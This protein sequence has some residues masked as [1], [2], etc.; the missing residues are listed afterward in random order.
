MCKV[1]YKLFFLEVWKLGDRY[2]W[3]ITWMVSITSLYCRDIVAVFH[4]AGTIF[5]LMLKLITWH[6]KQMQEG[7]SS[8]LDGVSCLGRKGHSSDVYD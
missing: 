6:S 3:A 1:D 2:R 7:N 5:V 4:S 8:P